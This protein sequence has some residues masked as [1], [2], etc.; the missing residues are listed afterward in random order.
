MSAIREQ[1][2][3]FTLRLSQAA[4][5]EAEARAEE[6]QHKAAQ[7]KLLLDYMVKQADKLDAAQFGSAFRN[8]S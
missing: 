5:V 7:Q 8:K 2:D 4:V 3:A 1:I 6:A